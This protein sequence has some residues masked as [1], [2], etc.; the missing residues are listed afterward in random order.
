MQ[1]FYTRFFEILL[2]SEQLQNINLILD[3]LRNSYLFG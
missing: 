2:G 3:G 1:A